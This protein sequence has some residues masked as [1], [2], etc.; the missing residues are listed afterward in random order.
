[1]QFDTTELIS[2]M[3]NWSVILPA[4][5]TTILMAILAQLLGI[6]LGLVAAL[7]GRSRNVAIHG[8]AAVY[9]W[10]FRGT[11]VLVQILLLY[12]GVPRLLGMDP[13]PTNYPFLPGLMGGAFIAATLALGVNEGAYMSEIFRAGILSV[14]SGQAE[15]AKSLGMTPRKT[16]S[17]I[18]LPQAL[19]VIIPP[20]GNEFNNMIKTTSLASVITVTELVLVAEER[21]SGTFKPFE[22]FVGIS[23]YYLALTTIW[24]VVQSRIER[25]LGA[26]TT[27]NEPEANLWA[28]VRGSRKPFQPPVSSAVPLSHVPA[29][30][31]L[32]KET[33]R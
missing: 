33:V 26:G 16:M 10:I 21:F 5:V 27:R 14:D 4:L 8:V 15:A 31:G 12:F 7:A 32:R 29:G 18:V 20:L 28:R 6:V 19:R 25:K 11:P 13:F 23:F 24:G 30:L 3:T 22:A 1:M 9:V 17:R 2:F